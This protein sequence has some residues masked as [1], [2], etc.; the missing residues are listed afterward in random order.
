MPDY[1]ALFLSEVPLKAEQALMKGIG[2]RVRL[3]IS[4]VA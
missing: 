4:L 1:L 3:L 2:S